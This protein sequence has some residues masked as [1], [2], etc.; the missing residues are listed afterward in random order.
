MAR[1]FSRLRGI[2]TSYEMEVNFMYSEKMLSS[3]E[4]DQLLTA[5]TMTRLLT[6][7]MEHC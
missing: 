2:L 1:V 4:R 7:K 5:L 6:G 3:Y